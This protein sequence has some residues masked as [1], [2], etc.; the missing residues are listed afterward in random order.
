M[1]KPS[2]GF[3]MRSDTNQTVKPQ[4]MAR[5]LKY[6][7]N[8]EQWLHYLCSETKA[9]INCAVTLCPGFRICKMQVSH[10]STQN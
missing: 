8:E 7:I 10:D 9:L 6:R 3:P 1:R 4:K 5:V 2:S